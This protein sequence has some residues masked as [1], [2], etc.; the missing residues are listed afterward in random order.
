MATLTLLVLSAGIMTAP[1]G[2]VNAATYALNNVSSGF[3][4]DSLTTGSTSSWTFGGDAAIQPGAR[5]AYSENSSGLHIGV[6]SAAGGTW[7]GY[8][9][10]SGNSSATLFHAVVALA[11]TSVPD[12]GFITG[13]YV[14]TGDFHYIDYV[15]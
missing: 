14:Q 12:N 11:Y 5:F 13:I 10:V 1:F 7:S 6:Q 8:Y 9:A 4:S 2:K 15:G 3:A